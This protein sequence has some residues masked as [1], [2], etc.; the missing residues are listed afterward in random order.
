MKLGEDTIGLRN[1]VPRVDG[2]GGPV[3]NDLG[4]QL[5]DVID[6]EV[7]WCL[8][9]P[10][11]RV[12]DTTEP[13]GRAAPALSGRTLLAPPSELARLGVEITPASVVIWPI[14]GRAGEGP[15]LEL[16][17]RAWQVVGEPHPWGDESVEAELRAST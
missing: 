3:L 14:T 5:V 1:M 6:V 16:S 10:T 2:S 13:E 15:T 12:S 9:A 8:V 7:P 4:D 17:G 11:G